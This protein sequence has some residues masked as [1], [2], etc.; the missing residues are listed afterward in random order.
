MTLQLILVGIIVTGI[1]II[2]TYFRLFRKPKK[3]QRV[4]DEIK[5]GNIQGSMRD[6]RAH[7]VR[8]GGSI[9]AHALLAECYRREGN[10]SM[11]VVEYR[12]GLKIRKKSSI[13]NQQII[14][15]GLVE[16]LLVLNKN[17]EALSELLEL[18]RLD[19][20]NYRY[21]FEIA[22]IFYQ[23]GNLEQA[24]TYFDKTIRYNPNHA[25]SLGYLGIIM[26]H[27]NKVREA[28]VYLTQAVRY[29][30][31]NGRSYYYLGRIYM[32][33][34]D[35][36]RAMTYFE[37]SQRSPEFRTRAYLQKG[38]CFRGIG[39]N[40]HAVDEY[41]KA[42]A[43]ATARDQSLL[44][45][46]RYALAALLESWGKLA[47]AIEQWESII[48]LDQQ[49]KDVP[50]KLEEYQDLRA[51]DNMKDFLVS[52]APMFEGF[53]VEIVNHLGYDIVDIQHQSSS[54]TNVIGSPKLGTAHPVARQYVYFKIFRDA[55]HLGLNTVKNLLEEAKQL[56]CVKAVCISPF[57][58]RPE[59]V[60]F[61]LP[62]QID[63]IG[64]DQLSNILKEIRG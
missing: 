18:T 15:E 53:C 47:E 3:L 46:S 35:Y 6:L 14:R 4:W 7:I 45:A 55:V 43:S 28:V 41:R 32:D 20:R 49:Y 36:R 63:L 22:K 34:R 11:A 60:D 39:D 16:C 8:H 59:A 25:E 56:R 54:V 37:A 62:R 5:R 17:D 13:L 51:D 58:F 44:L 29:D 50:Q 21:L 19:P 2:L 30:S 52:T 61:T 27:A 26:Y 1:I 40:E 42:I 9:D 24:V 12:H 64:A 31:R 57:T 23:K 10:C 33:G 38:N 48:R